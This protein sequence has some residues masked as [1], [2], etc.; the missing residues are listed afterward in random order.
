[1]ADLNAEGYLRWLSRAKT[2]RSPFE[3]IWRACYEMTFPERCEGLDGNA[4]Q[5][6]HEAQHK[7]S[8]LLDTTCADAART[9]A[10]QTH[11]GMTPANAVWAMLDVGEESDEER[12]WLDKA[13]HVMWERIH[14]ANYD[15][16]KY[17]SVLD[18][19]VAGWFVL[20][21]D[22]DKDS[23]KLH[24]QQWPI[25]QCYLSASKAG[26]MVDSL[27]R[28][29]K[30][31]AE[32][33]VN[34]YGE[35]RLPGKI[36]EDARSD[37]AGQL[38]GFVQVIRPRSR[39][40]ARG[41]MP[42]NMPIE[43]V[44]ICLETK[45]IV[46][47]SGYHEQPFVA[48]RWMQSP[49]S[50]YAV[51]PV[52][53]ALPA[54][55]RLN[56]LLELE[57]SA[58]GR[59]AAGVYVAVDDGVLNPRAIKVRGGSVIVANSKDSITPLPSG[60]EFNVTFTKADQLRAEIRRILLADQLQPQDGP[61]MTATEVHVRVQLIRQLFGPLYG[62]FQNED[63]SVTIDRVFGLTYRRGRPELGGDTGPVL[64]DDPPE[65]LANE[66]FTVR[67]QSP[68][69]RAQKLEEVTAVER[70][71]LFVDSLV[72]AG[73]AEAADLLDIDEA[74]RVHAEGS[75]APD[76]VIRDAKKVAA[77]RQAREEQQAEQAQQ[78]QAQQMQMMAAESAMKQRAVPA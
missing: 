34:E 58:L 38:Y 19:V 75:G 57:E 48:A 33:A 2:E 47:E 55:R 15:S 21:I 24:F 10:S 6:P 1:V 65:T 49:N 43:S 11:S 61:A 16:Q 70:T 7:R 63:L 72:K 30:L 29:F 53:A 14:G 46:R 78:A 73:I 41:L 18:A 20:F 66:V 23:G 56:K 36:V 54:A 4:N 45:A 76:R 62:R 17:E 5:H 52:A 27:L 77:V 26:G 69:A 39:K 60:A 25:A 71:A 28:E 9:L 31:T 51:G 68:L 22:E 44:H 67:Y 50:V 74:V 12:R 32:Q 3:A 40:A 42:K 59:A 35:D 8:E 64:L 37:K 13:S